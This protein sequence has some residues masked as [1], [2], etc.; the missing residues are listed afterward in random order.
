M[1]TVLTPSTRRVIRQSRPQLIFPTP[2]HL[3]HYHY[4]PRFR[5]TK[6]SHAA[7]GTCIVAPRVQRTADCRSRLAISRRHATSGVAD[8]QIQEATK[9]VQARTIRRCPPDED[10]LQEI[11]PSLCLYPTLGGDIQTRSSDPTTCIIQK[12]TQPDKPMIW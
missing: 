8:S 10:V 2:A 3:T 11:R 1:L 9:I 6:K 5:L 12:P 7:G 4:L